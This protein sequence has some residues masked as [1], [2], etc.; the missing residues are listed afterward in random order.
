ML[1]GCTNGQLEISATLC[2]IKKR[3]LRKIKLARLK[4]VCFN[5]SQHP[6]MFTSSFGPMTAC[7]MDMQLHKIKYVTS[8]QE[9][10]N[11]TPLMNYHCCVKISDLFC[12]IRLQM[13]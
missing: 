12:Q 7:N 11:M 8:E 10:H 5:T 3:I 4:P 1:R 2:S 13:R 6:N 9:K